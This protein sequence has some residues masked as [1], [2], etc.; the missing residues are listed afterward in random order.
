MGHATDPELEAEAV[1]DLPKSPDKKVEAHSSFSDDSKWYDER[2]RRQE[3]LFEDIYA[4]E[5]DIFDF[6]IPS[7][8]SN[9][10]LD[11]KIRTAVEMANYDSMMADYLSE[12]L[13]EREMRKKSERHE[14]KAKYGNRK[15]RDSLQG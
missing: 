8:L 3:S 2:D 5:D 14:R 13:F 1:C 11:K 6:A 9:R 7:E 4:C 12:L 10:E 15:T